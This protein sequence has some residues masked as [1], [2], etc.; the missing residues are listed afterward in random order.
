M[1]FNQLFTSGGYIM[2]T[3][4]SEQL[5]GLQ[6]EIADLKA[7]LESSAETLAVCSGQTIETAKALIRADLDTRSRHFTT[8]QIFAALDIVNRASAKLLVKTKK[9]AAKK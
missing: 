4:T 8:M 6:A 7:Q 9:E 5:E 3:A 1:Q 2:P